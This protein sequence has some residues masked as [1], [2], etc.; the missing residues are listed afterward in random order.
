M[1]NEKRIILAADGLSLGQ[2]LDLASEIGNWVYAIKIHSLYD[3][4]GPTVVRGLLDAGANRVW[5]DAKLYDIPNTVKLRAQAIAESGA[6]ILTVH[7]SGEVEMMMAAVEGGPAEVYAVTVL[8]SMSEEQAHL[9][10][11]QPS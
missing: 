5:V 1:L 2:C 6:D 11:G 3:Q 7:A 8:T 4:H 9:T 10:F